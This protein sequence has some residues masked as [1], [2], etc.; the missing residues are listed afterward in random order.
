MFLRE[1][2]T[3][4]D[5]IKKN[6]KENYKVIVKSSNEY[7]EFFWSNFSK[8]D[9]KISSS[10]EQL[11]E[12]EV[13]KSIPLGSVLEKTG[14]TNKCKVWNYIYILSILS[15]LYYTT[16]RNVHDSDNQDNLE[17]IDET[18]DNISAEHDTL[19]GKV[20]NIIGMKL[21][22]ENC[23]SD[24]QDV[25]DDDI[26]SLIDKIEQVD[27]QGDNVSDANTSTSS[28][29]DIFSMFSSLQNSKICNLAKEI[30][31]EIDTSDLKLDSPEDIMKLMDFS[32]G[33][34][35]MLSNII[36]K[37]SSKIQNK[38]SNGEIKHEDLLGEAMN[39]MSMM[40]KSGIGNSMFNNPMLSELMKG[41]K[42]GK[43]TPRSDILKKESAKERLRK[44]FQE[45]NAEK[46]TDK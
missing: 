2:K 31:S 6:V 42:S 29:D 43:V 3:I 17:N 46:S 45:K 26:R 15:M 25:I 35:N 33:G 32:G 41:M 4:D 5:D 7:I 1:I 14:E 18:S 23:E 12:L 9:N 30:S 11:L 20:I 39:M 44:K 38:I 40:T 37:V 16:P 22:G 34:P 24:L 8:Y 36:G 19:F 28:N 21:R 10:N 27:A 13:F